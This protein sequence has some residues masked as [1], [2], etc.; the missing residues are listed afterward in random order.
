M[1]TTEQVE[2]LR[3]D[4][5]QA[6]TSMAD[7]KKQIKD[8]KSQL[9]NLQ[10]G[11]EEYNKVLGRL[12]STQHQ[13]NEVTRV[14]KQANADLGQ[15]VSNSAK[16]ISGLA[17]TMSLATGLMSMMGT[18]GDETS[19]SL[20]KVTTSMLAIT[21]GLSA[22]DAGVKG[23]QGL[24]AAAASAGGAMKLLNNT[25]KA[26]PYVA[27]AA[28]IAAL[29]AGIIA[30]NK[31][32]NDTSKVMKEA[33]EEMVALNNVIAD[34]AVKIQR[35]SNQ[36]QALG[37]NLQAKKKFID[38]NKVALHNM[39]IA[40]NGV[41]DAERVLVTNTSAYIEAMMKRKLADTMSTE[42]AKKQLQLINVRNEL[43]S[44]QVTY[45]E[46]TK[47][48]SQHGFKHDAEAVEELIGQ[49]Q[50]LEQEIYYLK[51]STKDAEKDYAKLA[52]NLG[53]VTPMAKGSG[54]ASYIKETK[55]EIDDLVYTGEG[56]L[57]RLNEALA[58]S[59]EFL[60]N[61]YEI[62]EKREKQLN[63]QLTFLSMTIKNLP[64]GSEAY[65]NAM[66]DYLEIYNEMM[67]TQVQMVQIKADQENEINQRAAEEEKAIL[68][69]RK[70]T[71]KGYVTAI[72]SL[73][74]SLES[75]LGSIAGTMTEGTQQWKNISIAKAVISTLQGSVSAFMSA[76]DSGIPYPFNIAAGAASSASVLASGMAEVSKIRN[77]NISSSSASTSSASTSSF[78]SSPSYNAVNAL[79]SNITN[80]RNTGSTSDIE[81]LKNTRV[82][83]LESDISRVQGSKKTTVANST[84]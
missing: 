28:A 75:I 30:L 78:L 15:V 80:V 23:L 44:H 81:E 52:K 77:T 47:T 53:V 9:L 48:F 54:T 10:E 73:T 38:E 16:A 24:K 74:S 26:N 84:F 34:D 70:A 35:M 72:S 69:Q 32:A 68:E 20:M 18:E 22:I 29:V 49:F 36:Y 66:A 25:I 21:T 64:E 12:A 67:Y 33:K 40:C 43:L 59:G 46:Y 50:K 76:M 63:Q 55:E 39:G 8:L 42:L 3:I 56:G 31:R 7:M 83:V 2:V 4:S 51:G 17:G 19:E 61:D 11:S 13:Y 62:L 58:L 5:S 79:G 6:V 71:Y 14:T 41:N 27:A 65:N 57:K 82:Y 1:A 37:N 45:D 60:L